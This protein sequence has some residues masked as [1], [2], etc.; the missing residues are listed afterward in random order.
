MDTKNNTHTENNTRQP[1]DQD[2]RDRITQNLQQTLFVEAGAGSGKT[3]ALVD[4]VISLVAS[5]VPMEKIAV[6][7]FTEKAAGELRHRIRQRLDDASQH[8]H[9]QPYTQIPAAPSQPSKTSINQEAARRGISDT[10][11]NG[12]QTARRG[13]SDTGFNGMLNPE[14]IT[15]QE[16]ANRSISGIS[17]FNRRLT[18][19]VAR[20]ALLQLD[21]AAVGTLHSFAQSLLAEY[22]VEAGLPPDIQVLDQIKTQID[23]QTR[24][25]NF[26]NEFL[27][28]ISM[29]V[30]LLIMDAFHV[31]IK[32]LRQITFKM[33]E[34]WDK[35]PE[36]SV[37]SADP[38]PMNVDHLLEII[39]H[40]SSLSFHCQADDDK[41]L[42]AIES[43]VEHGGKLRR[44]LEYDDPVLAIRSVQELTKRCKVGRRGS[45]KNWGAHLDET[46]A[47]VSHLVK[48]CE[49]WLAGITAE[50]LKRL[51]A[52]LAVFAVDSAEQRRLSGRLEFHDLLV[53]ARE[54]LNSPLHGETVRTA[55]RGRYQCLLLDEFQDTDPIQIEIAVMLASPLGVS[56]SWNELEY[57][58][59]RLFFVGDPKQSIYRF[60]GADIATYLKTQKFVHDGSGGSLETL[61]TN[62]RCTEPIIDWINTVFAKLITPSEGS[63]PPYVPLNTW[64]TA[65]PRGSAVTLLGT[66]TPSHDT[67]SENNEPKA[68]S[69]DTEQQFVKL[70]AD[71]LR[72]Y[73]AKEV[74]DAVLHILTQKWDVLSEDG[75]NW[76]PV[77]PN[78]IAILIP[79]RNSLHALTSA[80]EDAEIPHRTETSSLVYSTSEV[81][82]ILHT[83]QALA[84]PTDE[85]A[86]VTALR[87]PLYGCGDDDLAHWKF[88]VKGC[89]SL[90]ARQP[91][92]I[93]LDHPVGEALQHLRKLL[94]S[95]RWH[96]PAQLID[97]L[98]R[99]RG[100]YEMAVISNRPRDVWRRLRF[101]TAQ[102]QAW[103]DAGGQE[104]R[105][106][107]QWAH[108][109]GEE[110]SRV[111]EAILPETDDDSVRI[112][113]IHGSKGLEFPI[114]VISGMTS[115]LSRATRGPTV[116]FPDKWMLPE[117]H[118]KKGV[119]TRN[120]E[121][122]RLRE[123]ELDRDER[124][125]LLYVAC[126]RARDHLVV[127]LCRNPESIKESK[128]QPNKNNQSDNMRIDGT[129]TYAEALIAGG[130]INT[131]AVDF[132]EIRS[133]D[134]LGNALT[135]ATDDPAAAIADIPDTAR[136][137]IAEKLPDRSNWLAE[138]SECLEHAEIP[139]VVSPT[140]L[141][142]LGITR[143]GIESIQS[144]SD[145]RIVITDDSGKSST[146]QTIPGIDRHDLRPS[147]EYSWPQKGFEAAVGKAVHSVLHTVD[148]ATGADLRAE[149]HR[150]AVVE[151]IKDQS[152]LIAQLAQSALKTETAKKASKSQNWREMYVAARIVHDCEIIVEGYVDLM[153][154]SNEGL[155]VVDWKTDMAD[156]NNE[157][158]ATKLA[159]YRLQGAAYAA[160]VEA[161]TGEKVARVE[162]ILL[163]KNTEPVTA[164]ISKLS[165]AIREVQQIVRSLHV[166]NER[167]RHD[168]S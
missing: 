75:E 54:L 89:F 126:T 76:R 67:L 85:L 116:A 64:R 26:L 73:E 53:R 124:I 20:S 159:R 52:R 113:T 39:E 41:L 23:F 84:D 164:V 162:L 111:T 158:A 43:I 165:S 37:D 146:T 138:L 71:D 163:R 10:G 130:A 117:V 66:Q 33:S 123:H 44:I 93:P 110:Q 115:R 114:A 122:H 108:L 87:S 56:G 104:L 92:D 83:L 167:H 31:G 36:H 98:I 91:D 160:A 69:D 109:Q 145:V 51:T 30:P 137:N 68:S 46:R 47:T 152:D 141:T 2:A 153:Y 34:H 143:P 13:I 120:Y 82:D 121:T 8:P 4:R 14:E 155:V 16:I 136:S 5:G 48:V 15:N 12:M 134:V 55:L 129:T 58:P 79:D 127:S 1:P 133:V 38:L 29:S 166:H 63:Q 21:N 144:T 142:R 24:W 40:L 86:L 61:T 139:Q 77:S 112:L 101:L 151:T 168:E 100:M 161:A 148:L 59:G 94:D 150:Q 28:D 6:I 140:K 72:A 27:D 90:I 107:L 50:A 119:H 118:I 78:D 18:P 99:E 135:S 32:Q 74:A 17:G 22:P 106:Y 147:S 3:R 149:A 105:E 154:R 25:H 125:R 102:A 11:F 49:D 81:R 132:E 19:Q 157:N 80:L 57:E 131:D 96:N 88:G 97:R 42:T 9:E 65:A 103:A 128:A 60:R 45:Q 62:F 7:T 70:A 95:K 35:L 156:T